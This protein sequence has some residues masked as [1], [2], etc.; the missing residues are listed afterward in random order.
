MFGLPVNYYGM[1]CESVCGRQFVEARQQTS[2]SLKSSH[3]AEKAPRVWLA[4]P[5]SLGVG[6]GGDCSVCDRDARLCRIGSSHNDPR[7]SDCPVPSDRVL[8]PRAQREQAEPDLA[9]PLELRYCYVARIGPSGPLLW[10]YCLLAPFPT[11]RS[12]THTHAHSQ[13]TGIQLQEGG[14]PGRCTHLPEL[15]GLSLAIAGVAAQ[16]R[17]DCKCPALLNSSGGRGVGGL[18]LLNLG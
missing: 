12:H 5:T 13:P 2:V 1:L 10:V 14:P 16:H 17:T 7:C 4:W 8:F 11:T 18:L 9:S 15:D 3:V 6:G